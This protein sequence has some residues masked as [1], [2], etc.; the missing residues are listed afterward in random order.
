MDDFFSFFSTNICSRLWISSLIFKL[1][2]IFMRICGAEKSSYIFF[3]EFLSSHNL[4]GLQAN[5]AAVALIVLV[6]ARDRVYLS[7]QAHSI[8]LDSTRRLCNSSNRK[9]NQSR[10]APRDELWVCELLKLISETKRNRM[11]KLE[12]DGEERRKERRLKWRRWM[13][14]LRTSPHICM[15]EYIK[16]FFIRFP[17]LQSDR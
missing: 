8:R 2:L 11:D 15:S 17:W 5:Q 9:K 4:P 16:N 12:I 10:I 1:L 7:S 3:S 14:R 13:D 6:V